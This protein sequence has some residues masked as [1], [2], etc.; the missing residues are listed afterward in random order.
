M[1]RPP[2]AGRARHAARS[3]FAMGM[4]LKTTLLA[5]CVPAMLQA[6]GAGGRGQAPQTSEM[7]MEQTGTAELKVAHFAEGCFWCAEEIF[8]HVQGVK[9]VING[10]A[11]GEEQ[12]PTYEQVSAGR[13]GH[14]EAVEV[15][16]DPQEVNFKTLV[17]VFFASQDPTTPSR[18][19]PDAGPQY[20]SIAFYSTPEEKA[21]IDAA[22]K[23][24][25]AS[26][27]YDRPVVTEVTPFT[28]FW[29]AEAYHQDFAGRNPGNPYIRNV[30]LPR[31]ERFK[32]KM[33]EVL[34]K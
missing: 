9:H 24:V 22:I 2:A 33:P 27:Q 6:C 12:D 31:L 19:G 32:Q 14:A 25:D 34:K 28:K 29:P 11:G 15:H 10:Y 3:T 13:T 26:G 1:D 17:D 7:A 30:S 18:Q 16:Y 23:A 20:R 21:V 5:L 4:P 8:Q